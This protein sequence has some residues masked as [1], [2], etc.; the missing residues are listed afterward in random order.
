LALKN[1]DG[2][3]TAGAD[4]M[5]GCP[6]KAVILREVNITIAKAVSLFIFAFL[7]PRCGGSADWTNRRCKGF[8]QGG[9]VKLRVA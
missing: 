7:H 1:P 4:D 8:L 6:P 5:T 2:G 3:E 9:R